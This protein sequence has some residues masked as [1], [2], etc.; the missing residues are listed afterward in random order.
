MY[1]SGRKISGQKYTSGFIQSPCHICMCELQDN[2]LNYHET[3]N[4]IDAI[5]NST[6]I[7]LEITIN[8]KLS[9]EKSQLHFIAQSHFL[10]F[11]YLVH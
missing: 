11:W 9:I 6:I 5:N 3:K 4:Q 8:Y 10:F 7:L 1:L 2:G